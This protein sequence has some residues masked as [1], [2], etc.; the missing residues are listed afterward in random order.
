LRIF[1]VINNSI[2]FCKKNAETIVLR[3]YV[4]PGSIE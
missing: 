3:F 4:K 1:S 2:L